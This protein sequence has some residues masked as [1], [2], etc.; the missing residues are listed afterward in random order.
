MEGRAGPKS[1]SEESL[2]IE[3]LV[4]PVVARGYLSY[5][6]LFH[7][8][9]R[10]SSAFSKLCLPSFLGLNRRISN[11]CSQH[12]GLSGVKSCR[13]DV[14]LQVTGRKKTL[15]ASWENI[16]A[17]LRRASVI[18]NHKHARSMI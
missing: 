7:C 6:T 1:S 8:R 2:P 11:G 14:L 5:L 16:A 17:K 12:H 13:K 15:K 18:S 9:P 3:G 4:V 10:T